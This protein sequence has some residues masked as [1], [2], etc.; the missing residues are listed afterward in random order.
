MK[1][2]IIIG[3]V[4]IAISVGVIF[5]YQNLDNQKMQKQIV[6]NDRDVH[7]CI[8]SAGYSWCE[9][10]GKCL[11]PWEE[12]CEMPINNSSTT[13]STSNDTATTIINENLCSEKG[14]VWYTEENTCEVNKLTE[15]QCTDAGGKFNPCASACRHDKNA[16]VCTMQCVLTCTFK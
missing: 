4:F 7:G 9:L 10:K 14:G 6:G 5:F 1:N 12:A 15:S 8:G 13:V 11:R 16:Q 3:L 2:K